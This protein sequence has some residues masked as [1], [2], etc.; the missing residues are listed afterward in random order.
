MQRVYKC[1]D[2]QTWHGYTHKGGYVT[3]KYYGAGKGRFLLRR[4]VSEYVCAVWIILQKERETFYSVD[5]KY[6]PSKVKKWGF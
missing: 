3:D 4:L 6:L 2:K 5:L 1:R